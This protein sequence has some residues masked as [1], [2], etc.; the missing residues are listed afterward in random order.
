MVNVSPGATPYDPANL[1]NERGRGSNQKIKEITWWLRPFAG[2]NTANYMG[3][4]FWQMGQNKGDVSIEDK[5]ASF[6]NKSGQIEKDF[7]AH[8]LGSTM[9]FTI[10]LTNF[11]EY[12]RNL[13]KNTDEAIAFSGTSYPG[14]RTETQTLS[15]DLIAANKYDWTFTTTEVLT[16]I[17]SAPTAVSE[18]FAVSHAATL[19]IIITEIEANSGILASGT[20]GVGDVITIVCKPGY[21]LTTTV[22]PVVTLGASQ[23][24]I[25]IADTDTSIVTVTVN[26]ATGAISNS[27]FGVVSAAG[28]TALANGG[29]GAQ[30]NILTGNSIIGTMNEQPHVKSISGN[31][32]TL[33]ESLSQ[34]PLDAAVATVIG[35]TTYGSGGNKLPPKLEVKMD[36][37][38]HS[39]L[40]KD[41]IYFYEVQVLQGRI[42]MTSEGEVAELDCLAFSKRVG[43][44]STA[45]YKP[46]DS[47]STPSIAGII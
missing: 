39:G 46:F 11:T 2:V 25:A 5:I 42:M 17:V 35:K 7:A 32:I 41:A 40:K 22:A 29:V 33:E 45:R 18:T 23:P 1:N 8:K 34:L 9:P 43:S 15:V 14:T 13:C 30:L 4:V 37:D 28:L 27:G 3:P 16:G 47:W 12:V 10:S 31:V 24:T 38:D 36:G 19:A 21:I 26:N 44:G 6:I 20:T